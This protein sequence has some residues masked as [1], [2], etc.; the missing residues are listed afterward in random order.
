MKKILVIEDDPILSRSVAGGLEDEGFSVSRAMD[1]EEG[2]SKAFAE[3]PDLI[4]LDVNLPKVNGLKVF[5]ELRARQPWRR[6]PVIVFTV[7]EPDDSIM[8]LITKNEPVYYLI[9][10][11]YTV[12]DIV[13]KIKDIMRERYSS[14]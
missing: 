10:S 2:L 12:A 6:T 4:L 3:H 9:K 13:G 8:A 7:V 5:D 1:G 11:K 14:G